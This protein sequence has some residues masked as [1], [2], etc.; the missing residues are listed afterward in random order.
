MPRK[1]SKKRANKKFG[2]REF[3]KTVWETMRQQAKANPIVAYLHERLS[4]ELEP[5][6][7]LIGLTG[8]I[9]SGKSL[10]VSF[11][12]KKKV[13]VIEADLIAR[14][15]VH[16]GKPAYLATIQAFGA[17]ILNPDKTIDRTALGSLV[18]SDPEKRRLLESITHPEILKTIREE[19]SKFKKRKVKH[20][21]IDAPLLFE[22]GLDLEM[23]RILLV[24]ID[25][26]IQI[27]RLMKRDKIT[28]PEA[29]TR[30]LAQIPSAQKE[31]RSDYVIDNSGTPADTGKQFLKI[32]SALQDPGHG[33]H[34]I[35]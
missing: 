13:P 10:I 18:F 11:L 24:R 27:K 32:W 20:L 34:P 17:G 25:P 23:D 2:E 35:R 1:K 12:K 6:M 21:V 14:E 28:E 22:A 16:P 4:Q 30:I 3:V 26:K 9:A 31:A 19:I 29:W 15:V 7:K 33:R 5:R 8:G